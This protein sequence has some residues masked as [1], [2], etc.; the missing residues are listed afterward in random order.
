MWI[1]PPSKWQLLKELIRPTFNLVGAVS[2]LFTSL[3][4]LLH[5]ILGYL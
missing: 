2:A 1:S 3:Y 4:H 5:C